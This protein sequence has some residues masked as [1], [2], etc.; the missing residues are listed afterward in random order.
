MKRFPAHWPFHDL[1]IFDCDS[2]LSAI[3]GIDEL[4]RL[5]GKQDSVAQLTKRAMDGDIP[6]ED[7]Y[8][9]RL[10]T[11]NPS[12]QQVAQIAQL[13]RRNVINDAKA[14]ISLLKEAGCKIFIVS[15]GLY[16]P[17]HEFG[18]WLD[19]PSENIFAVGMAFD[20][21]V[22]EWWRYWE[23]ETGQN[24]N[25]NY[26]AVEENPLSGTHGKNIIIDKIR[27]VHAG[28]ATLIGDGLS[29]ME[30]SAHVDLFI[31]FGGVVH[32]ERIAHES[33]VYIHTPTLSPVVPLCLGRHLQD[34]ALHL[35]GMNHILAGD[36]TFR[37]EPLKNQFLTALGV[38][39]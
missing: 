5:T 27:A 18:L 15:G 29:D 16:A 1:V 31:G 19:V 36:V 4:A 6:L 33:E 39:R 34:E 37:D 10:H 9:H 7:V 32:R 22:G 13:Y 8:S 11:S 3:E 24:P 25:A 17:V 26:L 30:A 38:E 28:R 12:Q 14:V 35:D 23:Q 2:T 21:L 20:Q